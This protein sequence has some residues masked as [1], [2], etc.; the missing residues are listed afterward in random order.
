MYN[1]KKRTL[2]SLLALA[3]VLLLVGACSPRV[4]N[5]GHVAAES[6]I[7]EIKPNQSNKNDV[8]NALGSPSTTSSFGDEEWYYISMRKETVAF[9]DSDIDKQDVIRITFDQ[10]GMVKSVDHFGKKDSKQIAI[11]D[12]R[13]PTAGHKLSFLEQLFGNIGRF[14]KSGDSGPRT[15]GPTSRPGR[16]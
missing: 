13:T 16:P 11:D 10:D 14:N 8:L 9:L 15:Y 1:S 7:G 4:D 3:S 6:R 2:S 12:E 5:R